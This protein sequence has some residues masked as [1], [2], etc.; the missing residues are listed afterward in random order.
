MSVKPAP[1]D[2]AMRKAQASAATRLRRDRR[3]EERVGSRPPYAGLATRVVGFAAD[4]AVV[5]AIALVVAAVI[6][7]CVSFLHLPVP[8]E[9]LLA[10]IGGVVWIGWGIGY[11]VAFWSSSGQT[12][13]DRLMGICVRDADDEAAAIGPTR[14]LLRFVGLWLGAIP[15]FAGYVPILLEE[16]RRAFHDRLAGTVVVYGEGVR[17]RPSG[18]HGSSSASEVTVMT[19]DDQASFRSAA[20]AVVRATR[21]FY[22]LAEAAS[23]AEA[24]DT[25]EQLSPQL[26]LMDVRMPDIDGVEATRRLLT[27]RPGTV[28]VL[29]SAGA[30]DRLPPDAADCGAADVLAK[31]DL[32]PQALAELWRKH[33]R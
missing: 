26:V 24:L 20:R 18:A 17:D 16:R 5:N 11:F 13:G 2:D 33:G 9:R 19:V 4:A 30:L 1:R 3:P 21:G 25:A 27:Q 32:G 6:A 28:V 31:Q 14:A 7:L 22:L 12:I 8:T 23:A 10:A 15:L 29:V